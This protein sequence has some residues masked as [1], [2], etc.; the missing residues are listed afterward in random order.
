[1]SSLAGCSQPRSP[2]A[3]SQPFSVRNDP[4]QVAP[5]WSQVWPQVR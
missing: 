2:L 1:M 5:S 4:P 3:R